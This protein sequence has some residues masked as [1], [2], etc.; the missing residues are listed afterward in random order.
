MEEFSGHS[1]M[2]CPRSL[3]AYG[4]WQTQQKEAL[5]GVPLDPWTERDVIEDHLERISFGP[6]RRIRGD[7]QWEGGSENPSA[8]ELTSRHLLQR[9][10]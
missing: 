2:T 5:R 1:E 7:S 8:R 6:G 10:H 9:S 3:L 4:T